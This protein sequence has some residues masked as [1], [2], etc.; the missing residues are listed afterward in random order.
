MCIR[1]RLHTIPTGQHD[2][3]DDRRPHRRSQDGFRR[4][5]VGEAWSGVDDYP[6][7]SAGD[8][9]GQGRQQL[10][11][12]PLEEGHGGGQRCVDPDGI[13]VQPG[14]VVAEAA[15]SALPS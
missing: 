14:G 7:H 1:D 13:A 9:A 2:A 12:S 10:Q 11:T 8:H 15:Q 3:E 4:P 6:E 5:N